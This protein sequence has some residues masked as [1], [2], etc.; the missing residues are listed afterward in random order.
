MGMLLTPLEQF[1]IISVF[2]I[3][4]FYLDFSF[5]NMLLINLIVIISVISIFFFNF[6]KNYANEISF[7]IIPNTWQ[8]LFEIVYEIGF[9][10]L[11]DNLNIQGEKYFP[12]VSVLFFFI[13]LNNLIGLVPYSFTI[14]SHLIVTF[15]LS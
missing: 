9:Q 13:L 3:K 15:I 7:F 10:L 4:F 1:Q 2:S 6:S 12:I 14:T 11:F 5:T 8:I